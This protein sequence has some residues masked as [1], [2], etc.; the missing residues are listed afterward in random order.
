MVVDI[1]LISDNVVPEGFLPAERWSIDGRRLNR[2]E[3]PTDRFEA[4]KMVLVRVKGQMRM[5]L[6]C[7]LKIVK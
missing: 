7:D 4:I 5:V 6:F 3:G 1:P 2:L